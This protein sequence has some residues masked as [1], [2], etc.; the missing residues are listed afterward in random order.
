MSTEKL[1]NGAWRVS[2]VYNGYLVSRVFY[3]YSKREAVVLFRQS[4][5]G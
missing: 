2:T 5:Q 4:L 3:G 1:H